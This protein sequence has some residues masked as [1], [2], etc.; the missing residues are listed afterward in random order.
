MCGIVGITGG[1]A[2]GPEIARAMAARIEHRGP[3][4]EGYHESEGVALGVRRLSIIDLSTGHQPIVA[5]DG[6]AIVFN[7]EIYN[8]RSLREEL[9][10]D[11]AQLRTASDTEVVLELFRREGPDAL[12]RLQGMF[13]FCVLDPA[14]R[15]MH[16]V[17]DRLGKKPLYWTRDGDRM[18]FASELKALLAGMGSRPALERQALHHYLTLRYVPGPNTVWAGVEKLEPGHRL[19]LDLDTGKTRV[20]RWWSVPFISQPV[21]AGRDYGAEFEALL[22]DAVEKRLVAADVPVGVLL[23]GGLDSSAVSAAAVELGHREFHTFSVG[24]SDDE[25]HS[26]LGWARRTAE[27]LGSVHHEVTIGAGAFRD[28]LDALVWDTDEPLADLASI[29]L[30]AVSRL[31]REHVKVVL[32][33]EGADEVLAGYDME[34]IAALLH[35]VRAVSRLPGPVLRS[36]ARVAPAGRGALRALAAGG[37]AGYLATMGA[38]ITR[39]FD[40]REKA[41]LWRDAG[42]LAS[43]D[44]LIR[45]WYAHAPS[46]E[47]I[48][49]LQQVYCGSWLVEDLLMKADKM[50][51]A[52]SLELRTPFLDHALVEW[53]ARAP[54]SLKVGDADVGWSS[55][56]I[57]RDFAAQRLPREIVNRPKQGFPVPAYDA[58]RGE[59]G[60]WAQHRLSVAGS[61]LS[62]L[63]DTASFPELA[64]RAQA[65][66]ASAAHK[67]WTLLVLDAW[68]E[69]WL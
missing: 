49:Q 23:S 33:G 16:L 50:T 20:E 18:L 47:P 1:G 41:R 29:P 52:A 65:G 57:L 35:R 24:Y 43:T 28:G 38:H 9:L 27:Q 15:R 5:S 66:D 4:D 48:D 26:E 19:E 61:A 42:D 60:A 31:A 69:R 10:A 32:S 44:E 56:R 51:M 30:L 14:R 62:D 13:A 64:T 63:L 12:S 68:L 3:D 36:A 59:L 37:R 46:P 45:S 17:R 40:E 67:V 6:A 7:G 25:R 58:L 8:Y 22:L 55:K 11:G 2:A 39:V 54:L 21:A 53:A 34:R